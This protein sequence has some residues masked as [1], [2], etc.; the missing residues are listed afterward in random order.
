MLA[1]AWRPLRYVVRVPLLLALLLIGLPITLL[2]INPLT[3][4]LRVHGERVD[5]R[6]IRSWTG[7]LVRLFG[8]RTRRVGQ[9]LPGAV[10]MVANHVSWIDISL[11]HSQYMAGFVAKDE[12]SR[13]P[14][15]GWLAGRAG[16]IYHQRGSNQS[17]LGVQQQML[18]RLHNGMA[19]AVFPEG[20][21]GNGEA[22]RVFHARI[23]QPALEANVPVQP[24]ALRY[25]DE[26]SAQ[27][28]VAFAPGE[29]FLHNF[30]RLLGDPVRVAEVHFLQP[31]PAEGGRRAMADLAR[32]RIAAA[33]AP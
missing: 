22:L 1:D 8:L 32:A 12:I 9:P 30:L 17:L 19:V 15:I 28:Q 23:L 18:D 14:L 3:H 33:L 13:W 10:L 27:T 11:L 25:G 24:V 21:T 6:V 16:T 26:G 7:A 2:L 31:V 20:G 4:R 5:E 29:Q